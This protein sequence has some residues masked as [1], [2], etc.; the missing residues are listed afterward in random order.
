MIEPRRGDIIL[1][2]DKVYI[3][4]LDMVGTKTGLRMFDLGGLTTSDVEV[5][6][7]DLADMTNGVVKDGILLGNIRD[8]V[9]KNFKK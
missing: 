3:V 8:I 7:A 4:A 5:A 6:A 9:L 2:F 1:Y